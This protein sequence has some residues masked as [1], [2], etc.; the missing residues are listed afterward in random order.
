M[1]GGRCCLGKPRGL[2]ILA[3]L[4]EGDGP[5]L[6]RIPSKLESKW[7]LEVEVREKGALARL[8]PPPPAARFRMD[9]GR[10]TAVGGV[11]EALRS[12]HPALFEPGVDLVLEA[13]GEAWS[14]G[15]SSAA[16]TGAA[17]VGGA[18]AFWHPQFSARG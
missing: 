12:A 17:T 16:A 2:G 11:C 15:G 7:L 1:I 6:A 5:A 18:S 14:S 9:V 4:G 3:S 10:A 8:E 13:A